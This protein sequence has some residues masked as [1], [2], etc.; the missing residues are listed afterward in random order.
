M[1]MKFLIRGF[2]VSNCARAHKLT[3]E[4]ETAFD[5]FYHDCRDYKEGASKPDF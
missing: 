2:C 5:V 3:T 1:C 4:D